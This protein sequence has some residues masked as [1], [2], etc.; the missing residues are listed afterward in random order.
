MHNLIFAIILLASTNIG[1]R[2]T[3]REA[4]L[5]LAKE[6]SQGD[7]TVAGWVWRYESHYVFNLKQLI[8][9]CDFC[10]AK[11]YYKGMRDTL[12]DNRDEVAKLALTGDMGGQTSAELAKRVMLLMKEDYLKDEVV[13][14][15]GD[16]TTVGMAL[17]DQCGYEF[18]KR[19][20]FQRLGLSKKTA[21][22][23]F[24]G[25]ENERTVVHAVVDPFVR[26]SKNGGMDVLQKIKFQALIDQTATNARIM[27]GLFAESSQN[28]VEYLAKKSKGSDTLNSM[29]KFVMLAQGISEKE[30]I[31]GLPLLQK[32]IEESKKSE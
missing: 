20:E 17:N 5:Q 29:K 32:T 21:D 23:Y 12:A 13:L 9:S 11:K 26:A 28:V 1:N 3:W 24:A 25:D 18:E 8:A 27:H 14:M 10:S 4:E 2:Q 6:V 7:A 22:V 19:G 31:T 30:S 15:N 16:K